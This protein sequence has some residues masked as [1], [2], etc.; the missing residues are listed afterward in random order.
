MSK[1]ADTILKASSLKLE[2]YPADNLLARRMASQ[3]L[4]NSTFSRPQ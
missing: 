2:N 4:V 3:A 1:N